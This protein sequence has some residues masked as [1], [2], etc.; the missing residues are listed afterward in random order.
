MVSQVS[1][2]WRF[3]VV[4]QGI[5]QMIVAP[6]NVQ[7][8]MLV[9]GIDVYAPLTLAQ[10]V[11]HLGNRKK[12]SIENKC[13]VVNSLPINTDDFADVQGQL[14]AKRALEI[15]AAGGHNVLIL[16]HITKRSQNPVNTWVRGLCVDI[17]HTLYSGVG[18]C[19]GI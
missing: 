10:L 11:L 14:V 18:V 6:D 3:I 7:E 4:K 16:G 13:S 5:K 15:A 9:E 8:A 2:L 19:I 1:C 12:L 17:A